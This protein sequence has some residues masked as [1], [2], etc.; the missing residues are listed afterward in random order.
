MWADLLKAETA[1]YDRDQSWLRNGIVRNVGSEDYPWTCEFCSK[2]FG[3]LHDS[4]RHCATKAHRNALW[5]PYGAQGLDPPDVPR[6]STVR[7][8]G[9]ARDQTC[10]MEGR[11]SDSGG[12]S[13]RAA[14]TGSTPSAADLQNLSS[15]APARI[16]RHT[17]LLRGVTLNGRPIEYATL[18]V[19]IRCSGDESPPR[20]THEMD[21]VTISGQVREESGSTAHGS[22]L[23]SPHSPML[24]G[25]SV[26][27]DPSSLGRTVAP[28][29]PTSAT[30]PFAVPGMAVV[31]VASTQ[32]PPPRPSRRVEGAHAGASRRDAAFAR[33]GIWR[34]QPRRL[35]D[36][37]SGSSEP[38][39]SSMDS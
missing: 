31:L 11:S 10:S 24:A 34:G 14:R 27:A 18:V 9:A 30:D 25:A 7:A 6:W 1:V 15:A 5:W 8:D 19:D 29:A 16:C 21:A 17:V 4:E 23:L 28:P 32:P 20:M 36:D 3:C 22:S 37:A 2:K 26:V 12:T 13:P 38:E 35:G 39:D 33:P